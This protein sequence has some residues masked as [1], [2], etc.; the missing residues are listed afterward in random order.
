MLM[1]TDDLYWEADENARPLSRS[2]RG[3][4]SALVLVSGGTVA[5]IC[6]L[7]VGANA[8]RLGSA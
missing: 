1:D 2:A 7:I 4:Q 3:R 5:L 8:N 6:P